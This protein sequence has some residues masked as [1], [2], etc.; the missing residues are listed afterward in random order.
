MS[1]VLLYR[2]LSRTPAPHG[3]E[4]AVRPAGGGNLGCTK[5]GERIL[6]MC[7]S[8]DVITLQQA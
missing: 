1:G 4:A 7:V 2:L 6:R 5:Y 3:L 8:L